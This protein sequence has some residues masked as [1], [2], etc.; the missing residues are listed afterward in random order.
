MKTLHHPTIRIGVFSDTHLTGSEEYL[1]FLTD[2]VESVLAPV[3]MILHAGVLGEPDVISAV[4]PI[5]ICLG[6]I[7]E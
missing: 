5:T 2:L 6:S 1:I 4:V 7:C 3:D